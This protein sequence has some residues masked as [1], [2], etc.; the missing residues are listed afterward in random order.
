MHGCI[1]AFNGKDRFLLIKPGCLNSIL[2]CP[3]PN[4]FS[5]SDYEFLQKMSSNVEENNLF[6]ILLLEHLRI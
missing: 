5:G 6:V 2:I 1:S 3:D 4:S